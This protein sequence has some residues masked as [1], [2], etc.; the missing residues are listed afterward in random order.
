[1]NGLSEAR[2]TEDFRVIKG[3]RLYIRNMVSRDVKM[4]S[5]ETYKTQNYND[6]KFLACK[7]GPKE[8]SKILKPYLK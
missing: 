8:N 6:T 7:L 2:G 5:T 4:N 1:M 3:R